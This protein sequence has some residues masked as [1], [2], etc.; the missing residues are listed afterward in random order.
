MRL[1]TSSNYSRKNLKL[2]SIR[3]KSRWIIY[4]EI[5]PNSMCTFLAS[6]ATKSSKIHLC[7]FVDTISVKVAWILTQRQITQDH[8]SGVRYAQSKP[9]CHI[10]QFRC[11]TEQSVKRWQT[12]KQEWNTCLTTISLG[13]RSLKSCLGRERNRVNNKLMNESFYNLKS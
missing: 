11:Q 12:S 13:T 7:S 2:R 10:F 6:A 3:Y 5:W 8:Q 4:N 9:K 1:Q